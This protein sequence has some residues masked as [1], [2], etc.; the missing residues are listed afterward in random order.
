M[1]TFINPSTSA[2]GAEAL[3]EALTEDDGLVEA[4]AEGEREAEGL[5]EVEADGDNEAD[6]ER[7]VEADGLL[8]AEG[9]IETEA[10]G[11]READGETLALGEMKVERRVSFCWTFTMPGVV[12]ISS[13]TISS[14]EPGIPLQGL[15]ARP[16]KLLISSSL[17]VVGIKTV[18]H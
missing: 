1:A 12:R 17:S 10:E 14:T 2:R 15:S 16:V 5:N 9:D 3:I 6:G 4:L 8:E 18:Y 7:D 13:P 11:E